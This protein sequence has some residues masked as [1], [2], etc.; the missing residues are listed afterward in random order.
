MRNL[1]VVRAAAGVVG[2]DTLTLETLNMWQGRGVRTRT[3]RS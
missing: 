1:I 2:H 3:R